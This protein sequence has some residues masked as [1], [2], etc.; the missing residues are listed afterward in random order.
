MLFYIVVGLGD[1]TRKLHSSLY[2]KTRNQ[3]DIAPYDEYLRQRDDAGIAA[4][5]A[6]MNTEN[7]KCPSHLLFLRDCREDQLLCADLLTTQNINA[8]D[9]RL[10]TAIADPRRMSLDLAIRK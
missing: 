9:D 3:D 4:S 6:D 1:F 2:G 10:Q 7:A 8:I 5:A